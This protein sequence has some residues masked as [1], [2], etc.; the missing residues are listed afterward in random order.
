MMAAL[1]QSG[2]PI[3]HAP[4]N[5]AMPVK[6]AT[7]GSR[8]CKVRLLKM[9]RKCRKYLHPAV[10][11]HHS[12]ARALSS[13]TTSEMPINHHSVTPCNIEL[14]RPYTASRNTPSHSCTA[15]LRVCY[16]CW[17]QSVSATTTAAVPPC[18]PVCCPAFKAEDCPPELALLLLL[19]IT[20]LLHIA[21]LWHNTTIYKSQQRHYG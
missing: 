7:A 19:P 11:A 16:C 13:L 9:P 1:W 4:A 18:A 8:P 2:W 20:I 3:N 10:T 15:V 12:T 6:K 5:A 14:K 21:K 17:A